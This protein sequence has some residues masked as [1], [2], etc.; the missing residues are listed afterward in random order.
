MKKFLFMLVASIFAVSAMADID[1]NAG[2]KEAA[3]YFAAHA[4]DFVA[5]TPTT[6]KT[7]T[8]CQGYLDCK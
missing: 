8:S 6:F 7:Y 5:V 2:E 4:A 1:G 3:A